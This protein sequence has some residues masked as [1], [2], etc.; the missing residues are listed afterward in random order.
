MRGS[1]GGAEGPDQTGIL[2]V[3]ICFLRNTGRDHPGESIGP[4]GPIDSRGRS[5]RPSVKYIEAKKIITGDC[6]A[7][8]VYF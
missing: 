6:Q 2:Q 5:V 8:P 7:F 1:R 3:A 4:L